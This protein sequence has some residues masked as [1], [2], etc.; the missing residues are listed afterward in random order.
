MFLNEAHV[1]DPKTRSV[2]FIDTVIVIG[3]L[4]AIAGSALAFGAV[5]PWSI[6]TLGL[7]ITSLLVLWVV[8]G[9]LNRRLQIYLPS[10]AMPIVALI[11]LGVLQGVTV[12]EPGGKR[13]SV[14]LDSEATRLATEVILVLFIAFLLSANF[15]TS[16]RN[17]TW[18]RNFLIYFGLAL[19][20]F[21]MLQ[22]FTWNGKLYWVIPL[23]ASPT[24]L[25]GPF[26][27]HSHFAGFVEMIAPIPVALILRRT[28]RNELMLLYGFAAAMMGLA[29][30]MS[31][32]RGGIISFAA[33][34][35]FIVVFGFKPRAAE[36]AGSG[37]SSLSRWGAM[38]V[39]PSRI[40]VIIVMIFTISVGVWWVGADPVI[41]RIQKGE[42]VMD[43]PSK[44]PG[45]ETFFQSRGY[46]WRDTATMIRENWVTGIGL[47]AFQTVYPIY[48]KREGA[49][50]VSQSHNDYLQ[51]LADGG[52]L[53]AILALW[54]IVLLA[55]DTVRASRHRNSLMAGTALGCSAGLFALFVHSLFDFN[56][57]IP[58]NALLFL[59]LSAV[60][61]QIA[62]ASARERGD[63]ND[64]ERGLWLESA[65]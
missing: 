16:P 48:S 41:R 6:A 3:L 40:G 46:I 55:R 15:L 42:L 9:A 14:S 22:R 54:F 51:I 24:S 29:V 11:L 37:R 28:V 60:V 38:L 53:G 56:F 57:Q 47:G 10:T 44:D 35:M 31:L 20:V 36:G 4:F 26:V 17:L 34:M 43:A 62:A 23:T 50:V 49:L 18:L 32:S 33:G 30:M 58:S 7:L 5:E 59:V 1:A 25:F 39:A 2:G 52:I 63:R 8:R 65:A 13:F 61:S 12:T 21:G 27:N 19:S 45:K 64:S